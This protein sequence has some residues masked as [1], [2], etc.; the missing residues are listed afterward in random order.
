MTFFTM[1]NLKINSDVKKI[2]K[3]FSACIC[4][5]QGTPETVRKPC[6]L[7]I[8]SIGHFEGPTEGQL[9]SWGKTVSL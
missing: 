3:E 2:V 7:I 8:L 4:G 5:S 9:N 6:G 1:P